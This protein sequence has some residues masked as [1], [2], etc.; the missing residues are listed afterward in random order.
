MTCFNSCNKENY[1]HGMSKNVNISYKYYIDTIPCA[2]CS[3]MINTSVNEEEIYNSR[4]EYL[5][6]E[7]SF[8][9]DSSKY[10]YCN[11]DSLITLLEHKKGIIY[12]QNYKLKENKIKQLDINGIEMIGTY[13]NQNI[14]KRN[15]SKIK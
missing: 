10:N 6:E 7:S 5:G 1:S 4:E 12:N 2:L 8:Y 11:N 14:F 15:N 13:N 9:H 3:G